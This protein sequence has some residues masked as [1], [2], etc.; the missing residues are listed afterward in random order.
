[1]SAQILEDKKTVDQNIAKNQMFLLKVHQLACFEKKNAI[2][3]KK[4]G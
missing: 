3:W 4:I 2:S 1:M